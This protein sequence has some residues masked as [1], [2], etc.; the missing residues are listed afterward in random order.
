MNANIF[1]FFE[2]GMNVKVFFYHTGI[3]END[4]NMS[5]LRQYKSLTKTVIRSTCIML[6]FSAGSKFFIYLSGISL[7]SVAVCVLTRPVDMGSNPTGGLVLRLGEA[8]KAYRQLWERVQT[9][10]TVV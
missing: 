6:H 1:T 9:P 8:T 2:S 5:V 3:N 10:D 4:A 7:S